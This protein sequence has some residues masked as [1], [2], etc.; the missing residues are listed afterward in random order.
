M[1]VGYVQIQPVCL[2]NR[3]NEM[4]VMGMF[5]ALFNGKNLG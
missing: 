2:E 4:K 3:S 5:S 1:K